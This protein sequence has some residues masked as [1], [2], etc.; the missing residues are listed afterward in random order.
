[1]CALAAA[2]GVGCGGNGIVRFLWR[3]GFTI[4]Q[5]YKKSFRFNTPAQDAAST[6]VNILRICLLQMWS[7]GPTKQITNQEDDRQPES[8]VGGWS[9]LAERT[10]LPHSVWEHPTVAKCWSENLSPILCVSSK[11]N[12]WLLTGGTSTVLCFS[13]KSVPVPAHP[14]LH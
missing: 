1:M 14:W 4:F 8:I 9:D 3:S 5:E 12:Q 2:A 13:P 10:P 11:S 7:D 6:Q